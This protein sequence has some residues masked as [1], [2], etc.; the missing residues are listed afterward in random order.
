[1][2]QNSTQ[3][4][5][6][7]SGSSRGA[8]GVS[9]IVR[10]FS[11]DKGFGFVAGDDGQSYFLHIK[12][13]AGGEIPVDGQRVTFDPMPT[14]KGYSAKA[15]TLGMAPV[16]IL[17]NPDR[18]T[19]TKEDE[20]RGLE[21]RWY[22]TK[23]YGDSRNPQEARSLLEQ[24]ARRHGGNAVVNLKTT[25]YTDGSV[26]S[27]YRFT[28]HRAEGQVVIAKKVVRSFDPAQI[29]AAQANLAAEDAY[30]NDLIA[31]QNAPGPLSFVE[32][33]FTLENGKWVASVLG[34]AAVAT[35]SLISK[36]ARALAAKY[37]DS[38]GKRSV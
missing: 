7:G 14:P 38:D 24:V 18:F 35:W 31:R 28:I 20:L 2:S 1:M 27:N 29:A 5:K 26:F 12:D 9:G 19:L 6:G 36:V 15:A 17:V 22:V 13:I 8:A 30:M 11:A 21:I 3:Q 23:A 16:E 4:I 37:K 34:R 10:S 32:Q 33:L 25:S